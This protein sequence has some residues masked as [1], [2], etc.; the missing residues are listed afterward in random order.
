MSQNNFPDGWDEDKARRVIA[1][2]EGQ[3][4]EEAAAEDEA[5]IKASEPAAKHHD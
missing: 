5:G 2:Y 3:T 1:H 4:E